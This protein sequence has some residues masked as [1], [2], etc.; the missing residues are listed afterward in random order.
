[1]PS[2]DLNFLKQLKE[3]YKNYDNFIETG[4]HLGETILEMEP[5]FSFLYTIEIKKDFYDLVKN[6][7]KG[8]KI[9]FYLGDSSEILEVISSKLTNKS[10]FFLDAHWS[11]GNTGKGKKHCPLYEEL[12]NIVNNHKDKCLLIIDDFRLFEKETSSG[13]SFKEINLNK[14]LDIVKNRYENH[15]FLPSKID[16]NDRLIINLNNKP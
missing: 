4:T 3:D 13:V 8:S 14:T 5:L 2:I 16:Q 9:D 10:I 6:K 7:Y 15:Y 1:M 11:A 12:E